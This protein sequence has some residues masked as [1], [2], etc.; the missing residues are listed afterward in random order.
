MADHDVRLD[1]INI[2][3]SSV[4]ASRRFYERL[5]LTFD[6]AHGNEWADRHISARPGSDGNS[7]DALTVDLDS[8]SFA[9]QWNVG[10]TGGP[11]VVLGFKVSSRAAVDALV[12]ELTAEGATVQQEPWDAFWGARYAV[13]TDPDGNAVGI[14]SPIDPAWRGEAPAAP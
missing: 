10:W 5:G 6:A 4:P 3:A 12:A 1:Q 8:A 14:M 7:S 13:V 2:V 9:Q 11:G